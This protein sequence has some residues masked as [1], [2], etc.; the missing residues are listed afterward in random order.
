[1][2][3]AGHTHPELR[4]KAWAGALTFRSHNHRDSIKVKMPSRVQKMKCRS[5]DEGSTMEQP[6]GA[7][8]DRRKIRRHLYHGSRGAEDG[9]QEEE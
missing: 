8:Q 2:Q 5:T 6:G 3:M 7:E 1:M 4:G 9:I